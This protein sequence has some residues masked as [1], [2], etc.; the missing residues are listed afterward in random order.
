MPIRS[1]TQSVPETIQGFEAAAED[2]YEDGFNLMA[3]ASPGNGVYLMGYAAEMLLK[4][5]YFRV[6][7]LSVSAPITRQELSQA[8]ADANNLGVLAAPENFHNIAFWSELIV[9]KRLRQSR[10]LTAA[11]AAELD[12]RSARLAQNWFVEMR[13]QLLQGVT[14]QDLEDVL[15]DVVW[16][17]SKHQD[18][19]R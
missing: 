5:A 15:D 7:G 10:G 16:I 12:L 1:Q 18:F 6:A 8:R 3:S 4:S 14:V 13:Y 2:K 9:K 11:L 17:K 19:W